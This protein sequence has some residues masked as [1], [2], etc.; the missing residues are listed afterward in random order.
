MSPRVKPRN[1]VVADPELVQLAPVPESKRDLERAEASLAEA[2]AAESPE[3]IEVARA[4]LNDATRRHAGFLQVRD[5]TPYGPR[6]EHSFFLDTFMVELGRESRDAKDRLAREMGYQSRP[7]VQKE[8]RAVTSGLLGS[9]V[10]GASGLPAWTAEAVAQAARSAAPL[11]DALLTIPLP[12]QGMTVAISKFT[13]GTAAVAQGSENTQVSETSPEPAVSFEDEPLSTIV[14]RLDIS[15]PAI[16]R[17]GPE[18]DV[19]ISDDIGAAIGAAIESE[20]WVGPGSGGRVRGF[21]NATGIAGARSLAA[22][23]L[24]DH[25]LKIHGCA[26]DVATTL[27]RNADLVAMHPRRLGFL[28][29]SATNVAIQDLLPIGSQLVS[30]P[31]QV[32]N[33]GNG[34][35]EDWILVA[36]RAST[37]LVT[38]PPQLQLQVQTTGTSLQAH[39]VAHQ[40]VALATARR[41]EGLALVKGATTPSF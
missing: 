34:T 7:E 28:Q 39:Y 11:A 10:P 16:D 14:A 22:Q 40:Y 24:A 20:L 19:Q 36:N 5:R 41:P 25:L 4:K 33:L 38:N 23:T 1:P 17:G 35:N 31:G 8:L 18:L 2:E 15:Y 32:T 37:P 9:I 3:R 12:P 27:G 26:Q 6:S 29:A 21:N 13:S 30:S